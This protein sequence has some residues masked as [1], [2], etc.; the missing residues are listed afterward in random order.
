[1]SAIGAKADVRW[2]AP[3]FTFLTPEADLSRSFITT[4]SVALIKSHNA[5]L[6]PRGLA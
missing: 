5:R 3:N 1:M 6:S 4:L 2:S